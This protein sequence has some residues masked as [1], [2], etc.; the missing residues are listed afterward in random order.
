MKANVGSRVKTDSRITLPPELRLR[1]ELIINTIYLPSAYPLE[2]FSS[3][4]FRRL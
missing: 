4:G 1:W 2:Y 3:A